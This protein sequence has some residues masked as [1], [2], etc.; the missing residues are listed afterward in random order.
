MAITEININ[1]NTSFAEY[2]CDY[3]ADLD[4]FQYKENLFGCIAYVLENE[5]FYIMD[6]FGEWQMQSS[7]GGGGGGSDLPPVTPADNGKILGVVRGN[8]SKV[9]AETIIPIPIIQMV[10]TVSEEVVLSTLKDGLYAVQGQHRI[11]PNSTPV[12]VS[13]SNVIAIVQTINGIKKI[14]YI[15]A[16]DL[17]SYTINGQ[18]VTEDKVATE[19]FLQENGYMT[20]DDVD[21][22]LAAAV[23]VLEQSLKDYVD[24]QINE[25]IS[26][27]P[28]SN[29][30]D[31]FS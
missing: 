24:E 27:I 10:G 15:T 4:K 16:D 9:D 18:S 31:L 13:A 3:I 6:S 25:Q 19:S 7:G 2:V 23:Q 28:E 29:I 17:T 30:R 14:K 1:K 11:A 12:F 21:T 26:N 5:A 20:E 8:W 22:K